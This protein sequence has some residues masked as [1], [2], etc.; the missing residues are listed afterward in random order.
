[1]LWLL[2]AVPAGAAL[3]ALALP[4]SVLRRG[5]LVAATGYNSTGHGRPGRR[6]G[7]GQRGEGRGE[8]DA[9]TG[10]ISFGWF[11]RLV[12]AF[13]LGPDA[14]VITGPWA[15]GERAI[16]WTQRGIRR[17]ERAR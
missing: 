17:H 7:H 15:L 9:L 8:L 16:T 1:M 2:L 10:T 13:V 12:G 6:L 5:L 3:L 4:W 14:V 11:V